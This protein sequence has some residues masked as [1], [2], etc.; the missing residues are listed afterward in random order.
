[1]AETGENSGILKAKLRESGIVLEVYQPSAIKKF[2][3]TKGNAQKIDMVIAA[4]SV[5]G[6]DFSELLGLSLK[7][8]EGN[9]ISDLADAFHIARM[10]RA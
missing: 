7:K 10:C 8:K 1:M 9:P 5:L 2:A 4:E 3:T 6:F